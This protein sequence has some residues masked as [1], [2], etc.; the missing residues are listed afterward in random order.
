MCIYIIYIE[1]TAHHRVEAP[2]IFH[3]QRIHIW[4]ALARR[5]AAV[6]ARGRDFKETNSLIAAACW[7]WLSLYKGKIPKHS[8]RISGCHA[9]PLHASCTPA[10]MNSW[11]ALLLQK[12][13]EQRTGCLPASMGFWGAPAKGNACSAGSAV[14]SNMAADCQRISGMIL[15]SLH[16]FKSCHAMLSQ[17]PIGTSLQA[18][19]PTYA[20]WL[21]NFPDQGPTMLPSCALATEGWDTCLLMSLRSAQDQAV[22]RGTCKQQR[23]FSS[24]DQH[25]GPTQPPS[26]PSPSLRCLLFPRCQILQTR[27]LSALSSFVVLRIRRLHSVISRISTGSPTSHGFLPDYHHDLFYPLHLW[28]SHVTLDVNSVLRDRFRRGAEARPSCHASQSFVF[29][30]SSTN[31]S[32][33]DLRN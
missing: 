4:T 8:S 26:D 20:L 24:T 16:P 28:V 18:K 27:A 9:H 15:L 33:V 3:E 22:F 17:N 11:L 32:L 14:H 2:L 1:T 25:S 21:A 5:A 13:G 30:E 10:A 31:R 7:V 12:G 19:R 29:G 6:L 23:M